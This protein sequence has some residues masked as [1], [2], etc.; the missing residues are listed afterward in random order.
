[1]TTYIIIKEFLEDCV[2]YNEV[3][4]IN[5]ISVMVTVIFTII[6]DIITL[7]LQLIMLIIKKIIERK[8][9]GNSK[10]K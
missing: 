1:M 8:L 4:Y 2:N 9:Y 6:F 7:P 10:N 5:L 3:P